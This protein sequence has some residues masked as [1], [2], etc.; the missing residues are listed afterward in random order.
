MDVVFSVSVKAS[1]D[2]LVLLFLS[3]ILHGYGHIIIF[4]IK[5]QSEPEQ[6]NNHALCAI[7]THQSSYS[8]N[9]SN[10]ERKSMNVKLETCS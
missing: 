7:F 10:L 5:G 1:V 4:L 8:F 9:A 6:Q 2:S 3:R